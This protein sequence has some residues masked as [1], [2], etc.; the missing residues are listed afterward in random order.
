MVKKVGAE[1]P[2]VNME[3]MFLLILVHSPDVGFSEKCPEQ[4]DG[5]PIVNSK[6]SDLETSNVDCIYLCI[7]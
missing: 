7:L 5:L 2:Q 4:E 1:M 6:L 3:F